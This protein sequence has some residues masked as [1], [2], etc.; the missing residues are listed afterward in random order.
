MT[1]WVKMQFVRDSMVVQAKMAIEIA[2]RVVVERAVLIKLSAAGRPG[3]RS[4]Y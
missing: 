2:A 4:E 1:G 3:D